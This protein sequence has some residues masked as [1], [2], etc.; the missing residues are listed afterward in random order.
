MNLIFGSNWNKRQRRAAM[1]GFVDSAI[2][3][4]PDV[5]WLQPS[6]LLLSIRKCYVSSYKTINLPITLAVYCSELS[7]DACL[8]CVTVVN[9]CHKFVILT[10]R[11]AVRHLEHAAE[12]ASQD[13]VL[14]HQA[15]RQLRVQVR[16]FFYESKYF[17]Q[18]RFLL[19][20]HVHKIAIFTTEFGLVQRSV[21][22]VTWRKYI[23]DHWPNLVSIF[24]AIRA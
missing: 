15:Y 7:Y 23:S 9:L 2:V 4:K 11:L 20:R 8:C 13:T 18:L 14:L 12:R 22:Y 5:K 19:Y 10:V 21:L 1:A 24:A 6:N 16:C 17:V 3:E